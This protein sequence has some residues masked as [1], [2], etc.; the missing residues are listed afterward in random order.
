VAARFVNVADEISDDFDLIGIVICDFHIDELVF[1]PYH[2]FKTIEPIGAKIFAEGGIFR[3]TRDIDVQ[4][5]GNE[6]SHFVDIKAF[7]ASR[8]LL[9]QVQAVKGHGDDLWFVERRD[10]TALLHWRLI[11]L[12]RVLVNEWLTGSSQRGRFCTAAVAWILAV[13]NTR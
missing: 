8:R 10:N 6:S 5:L 11:R 12:A 13:F 3:D 2:Q 1:N 4:L 7:T 9:R